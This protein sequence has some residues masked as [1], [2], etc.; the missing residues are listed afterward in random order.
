LQQRPFS[1]SRSHSVYA[2]HSISFWILQGSVMYVRTVVSQW[3]PVYII[4]P[5]RP[6]KYFTPPSSYSLLTPYIHCTKTP[7]T[8]RLHDST[9]QTTTV[10]YTSNY[11]FGH[12]CTAKHHKLIG[13][14][15]QQQAL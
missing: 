11:I 2:R 15:E 6:T 13:L 1:A 9:S 12:T 8:I 10:L 5:W 4:T 7:L 14:T 3:T